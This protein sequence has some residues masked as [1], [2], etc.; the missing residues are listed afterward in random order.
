MTETPMAAPETDVL[1]LPAGGESVPA[2]LRITCG[3]L[4]GAA[5]LALVALD[6][7]WEQAFVYA[8][9]GTGAV[10]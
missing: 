8:A 5:T 6:A 2:P 9:C 1:A 3:L 10:A 4:A 7:A